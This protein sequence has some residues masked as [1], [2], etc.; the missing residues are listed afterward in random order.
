MYDWPDAREGDKD[1]AIEFYRKAA[2]TTPHN[3]A[4][5]A[6]PFWKKKLTSLS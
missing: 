6:V 3:G 4:A 5:R 1:K 2:G